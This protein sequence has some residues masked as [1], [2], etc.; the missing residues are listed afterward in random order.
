MAIDQGTATLALKTEERTWRINIETPKGGDPVVTVHR[1]IV[2]TGPDGAIISR[3]PAGTVQRGL[4]AVA[5]ESHKVGG[6]TYS[7]AEVAGVIAAMA[8]AW[9]QEDIAAA[10]AARPE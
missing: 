2:R 6:H 1:E 8:D 3:D 4:S 10:A 5:T 7:T 9:R